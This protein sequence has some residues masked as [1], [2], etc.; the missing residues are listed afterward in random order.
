MLIVTRP[1]IP[2]APV[3]L[4][5]YDTV[6]DPVLLDAVTVYVP[7]YPEGSTPEIS[8]VLPTVIGARDS[9]TLNVKVAVVPLPVAAVGDNTWL[10]VYLLFVSAVT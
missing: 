2:K 7:L 10:D 8:M 3:V 4:L 1:L 6:Y 9:G 5:G